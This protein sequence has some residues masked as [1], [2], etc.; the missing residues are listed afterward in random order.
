MLAGRDISER[1][2]SRAPVASRLSERDGR[3]TALRDVA[4]ATMR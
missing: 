2:A 4:R 3:R 1:R